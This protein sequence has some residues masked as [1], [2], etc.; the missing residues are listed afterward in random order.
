MYS[1]NSSGLI[2]SKASTTQPISYTITQDSDDGVFAVGDPITITIA[3]GVVRSGTIEGIT[4]TGIFISRQGEAHGAF[5]YLTTDQNENYNTGDFVD[6]STGPDAVFPVCFVAGTRLETPS[7]SV[8]IEDLQPG[9]QVLCSLGM[10]TIKWVGWRNYSAFALRTEEQKTRCTPVRIRKHAFADNQPSQDLLVSP[11]HHLYVQGALVR[12]NDLING[13]TIT[14][15]TQ[16]ASVSYYHVELDKFDVVLA[17]GIYSESWADGG[18]RDFFQNVD[19]T[20]LRPEDKIRRR[21]PRPGFDHLV[22]RKGK[23]LAAI[24]SRVAQRANCIVNTEIKDQKAA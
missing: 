15:E 4:P 1:V 7:G 2:V 10:R 14:Q 20:T 24:Q 8:A 22:L 9:D 11:W 21:A 5:Q 16:T 19:V 23:E 6:V 13:T 12:A 17:H 18:N 3:P